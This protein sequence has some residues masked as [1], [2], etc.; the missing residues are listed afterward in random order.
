MVSLL[1]TLVIIV[2]PLQLEAAKDALNDDGFP[3][4]ARLPNLGLVGNI[5][6]VSG[7]LEQPADQ[8][9]GGLEHRRAHQHFQLGDALSAQLP[10]FKTGDQL[11]DFFLLGEEDGRRERNFFL[12]SAMFWRVSWMTRSA[13]CSVSCWY[14]A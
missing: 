8:R 1:L 14:W 5:G 10:R 6:P 12:A 13:Y 7:L 3:S 11:L 4:L 9:I 2:I